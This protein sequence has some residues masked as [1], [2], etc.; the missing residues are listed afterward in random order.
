MTSPFSER[1]ARR[2]VAAGRSGASGAVTKT[3]GQWQSHGPLA[4]APNPRRP[5]AFSRRASPQ[6]P[7]QNSWFSPAKI[8][9]TESSVKMRRIESAKV[10]AV[11]STVM[12]SGAPGRNGSV[13]ETTI[14][15]I[16]EFS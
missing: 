8:S 12:L 9:E 5:W 3:V 7:A 4:E 2:G 13:S 14:R 15:S 10:P 16:P 1:S 11:E 6:P